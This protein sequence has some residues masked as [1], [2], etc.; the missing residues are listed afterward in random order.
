MANTPA[1]AGD[2]Q[3]EMPPAKS[4][5]ETASDYMIPVTGDGVKQWTGKEDQFADYA[6]EQAKG[7]YPT[8]ATAIDQGITTRALLAPYEATAQHLLGTTHPDWDNPIWHAAVDGGRT[9]KGMPAPMTIDQWRQHIMNTDAFGYQ[10][11]PQ[12]K[13]TAQNIVQE[14]HQAM[15]GQ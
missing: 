15:G 5:L 8:F 9:D 1:K 10:Y 13:A 2:A 11:T 6:R 7:M 3:P 4:V 12:A 14:L